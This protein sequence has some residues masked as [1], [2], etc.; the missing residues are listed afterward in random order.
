MDKLLAWS[1]A[2]QS[3]DKEAMERIGQPDMKALNQLFGGI[4]E[5][6]LM[7]QSLLVVENPELKLEDREVAL[8]NFEMLIENLD[9]A[10]NIENMKM[11]PSLI[12]L[13]DDSAPTSLKTITCSIIGIA[14]QNNTTCQEHLLKHPE[15]V[16]KLIKI[17]TSES[18]VSLKLKALFAISS[19]VRNNS[20]ALRFFNKLDGWTAFEELKT[21]N[22]NPKVDI[23]ILSV[24]SSVLTNDSLFRH[25]IEPKIHELS[26]VGKLIPHLLS[27]NLTCTEKSLN[28]L[29]Q[30]IHLNFKFNDDE[31]DF[32]SE[33]IKKVSHLKE[34]YPHDFSQV[35]SITY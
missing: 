2:Q 4:D 28:I 16:E 18:D 10:N 35:E 17:L 19:L 11:W 21:K 29:A 1:V 31:L 14:V 32:L 13:L 9:N 23:R 22:E 5:P 27:D 8:E 12:K 20:N 6:T 24:L 33:T 3:G 30:L 15:G 34:E 7:K 25:E 26:L